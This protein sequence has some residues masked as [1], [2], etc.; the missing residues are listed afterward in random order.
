[1]QRPVT[2]SINKYVLLLNTYH[3]NPNIMALGVGSPI[4]AGLKFVRNKF[5]P[6]RAFP[7]SVDP[8][9]IEAIQD[10]Q[11]A[12]QSLEAKEPR[13]A[14]KDANYFFVWNAAEIYRLL[15]GMP[16]TYR[17]L[18]TSRLTRLLSIETDEK[19]VAQFVFD[20][21]RAQAWTAESAS[22]VYT[23]LHALH[24]HN[25]SIVGS[26]FNVHKF[27]S[28]LVRHG[29]D[30]YEQLWTTISAKETFFLPMSVLNERFWNR[31]HEAEVEM[32]TMATIPDVNS[33]LVDVDKIR[34]CLVLGK[35]TV[36][37]NWDK[38]YKLFA[39]CF[40]REQIG[41][42][43][44]LDGRCAAADISPNSKKN[45]ETA[46]DCIKKVLS[47]FSELVQKS[48]KH[49]PNMKR[50]VSEI[51]RQYVNNVSPVAVVVSENHLQY[52]KEVARRLKPVLVSIPQESADGTMTEEVTAIGWHATVS[53]DLTCPARGGRPSS[54]RK[55][56][57]N[58]RNV[59]R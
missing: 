12:V 38:A 6:P 48:P 43:L 36:D 29:T 32:F 52:L 30:L 45:W 49:I 34:G 57:R 1:M 27:Y 3:F 54:A 21:K 10:M 25:Q 39:F 28:E 44:D 11:M 7:T 40:A 56:A 41:R 42:F 46:Q 47:D 24:H 14:V 35:K 59:R 51:V 26:T 23:N 31:V 5:V 2:S 50:C 4:T 17:R 33:V 8:K 53:D 55:N 18:V 58:I 9:D 22:K 16:H 13:N 15:L 19:G 20:Y 37:N